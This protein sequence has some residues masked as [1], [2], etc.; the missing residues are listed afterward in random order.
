M[1]GAYRAEAL[2]EKLAGNAQGQRFLLVRASRGREIL[3][4]KLSAAGG[5]VDQ[6]VVYQSRDVETPDAAV[7]VVFG[8]TSS[9]SR[10]SACDNLRLLS[11][12]ACATISHEARDRST[13]YD[14]SLIHI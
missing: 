6:V 13:H 3:A 2:A 14:L 7:A 9:G 12:A 1:P 11:A 10:G 4:E 8:A 5:E